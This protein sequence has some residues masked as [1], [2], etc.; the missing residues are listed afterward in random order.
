MRNLM[1]LSGVCLALIGGMAQAEAVRTQEA[2]WQW[3]RA[4]VSLGVGYLTGRSQEKVYDPQSGAKINQ[5]FWEIEQ[6]PTLHAGFSLDP[7][8]WLTLA[9]GLEQARFGRQHDDRLRLAKR[10]GKRL[11]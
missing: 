8:P 10:A 11:E 5:L 4:Q 6:A 7:S 1:S 9:A 3:D 2:S